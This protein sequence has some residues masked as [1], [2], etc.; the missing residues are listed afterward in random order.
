MKVLALGERGLKTSDSHGWH[1][2][3]QIAVFSINVAA[4]LD[5]NYLHLPQCFLQCFTCTILSDLRHYFE[6]EQ[7]SLFQ[8]LR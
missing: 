5:I 1:T 3:I 4:K 6:T 8:F 2:H 7:A